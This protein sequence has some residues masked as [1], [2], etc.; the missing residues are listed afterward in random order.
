M[1]SEAYACLLVDTRSTLTRLEDWRCS[2]APIL[3]L[4][5]ADA[6][7]EW[8]L[9]G[10]AATIPWTQLGDE[11]FLLPP[12]ETTFA[13][14][15][16]QGTMFLEDEAT[17]SF[18]TL[19]LLKAP[20]PAAILSTF[21]KSRNPWN[22]SH[23][24]VDT[25]DFRQAAQEAGLSDVRPVGDSYHLWQPSPPLRE[26]INRIEQKRRHNEGSNSLGS[27]L[28]LGCGAGR[29]SAFLAL[30]GW[31]VLAVD[32]M[33][34]ALERTKLLATKCGRTVHTA[35]V[36][37][38]R[39]PDSLVVALIGCDTSAADGCDNEAAHLAADLNSKKTAILPSFGS[40]CDLVVISRYF[41]RHL[42]ESGLLQKTLVA[43][44]GIIFFRHFLD[45]VQHHPIGHPSNQKDYLLRGELRSAFSGWEVI[46][47]DEATPLPDGRP[48]AT[49]I[50][51]RPV[52]VMASEIAVMDGDQK[53]V[54][55]GERAT[56]D[57]VSASV[58]EKSSEEPLIDDITKRNRI[59]Y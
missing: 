13:I 48:M 40:G 35:C 27:C 21:H 20:A 9:R 51:Q 33:P 15:V 53:N 36:D 50:A 44:G 4:R 5:A 47:D 56:P 26:T 28:D 29:D 32:N 18:H 7:A 22:I 31:T 45:G 34:R 39:C 41:D 1:A 46:L 42:L 2:D 55:I 10:N 8:R 12:R 14:L 52:A 23:C 24:F 43:P 57:A 16:S 3:D 30:R 54:K 17:T 6:F 37:L 38:K 25:P 49:F 59:Y 19:A 11:A 58:S